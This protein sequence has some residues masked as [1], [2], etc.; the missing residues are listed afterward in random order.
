MLLHDVYEMLQPCRVSKI[1]DSP[2]LP[3][4]H[5]LPP[6]PPF[7]PHTHNLTP[8]SCTFMRYRMHVCTHVCVFGLPSLL[9]MREQELKERIAIVQN[10]TERYAKCPECNLC[11]LRAV[12][13]WASACHGGCY[14]FD[15]VEHSLGMGLLP[16][17]SSR[18]SADLT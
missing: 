8:A 2:V 10:D 3:F 9:R 11:R 16:D 6:P 12:F 4:E 14:E 5:S 1:V 7:L 15:V 18:Y 17:W 13:F